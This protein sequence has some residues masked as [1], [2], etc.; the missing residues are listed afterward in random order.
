MTNEDI[1]AIL[2]QIGKLLEITGENPFKYRAY[3]NAVETIRALGGSVEELVEQRRLSS[4]KGFGKALTTKITEL[5]DTGRLEYYEKLKQSVSPGLFDIADLPGLDRRKTG[6]LYLKLGVATLEDLAQACRDGRVAGVR[7]FN[8][9][10]QED[11][12]KQI[13]RKKC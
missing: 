6:L 4:L 7:G 10:D 1:C 5:V 3:F 9:K 13:E 11:L 8:K 12:L 2:E